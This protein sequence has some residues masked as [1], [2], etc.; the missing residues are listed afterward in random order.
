MKLMK[1]IR[2]TTKVISTACQ[3]FFWIISAFV[4]HE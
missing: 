4:V 1:R 2:P 3:Y